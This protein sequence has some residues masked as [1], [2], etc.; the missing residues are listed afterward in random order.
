MFTSEGYKKIVA[1]LEFSVSLFLHLQKYKVILTLIPFIAIVINVKIYV[2]LTHRN[3]YAKKKYSLVVVVFRLIIPY[4]PY[5]Q[6]Y[7]HHIIFVRT[8]YEM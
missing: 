6:G 1:I 4:K 2:L 5:I 3:F 8:L 7:K